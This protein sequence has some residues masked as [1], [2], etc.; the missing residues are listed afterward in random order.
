M[1]DTLLTTLNQ[2]LFLFFFILAGYLLSRFNA[3]DKHISSSL[4]KLIN[5]LFTPA[6]MIN[7]FAENFV[8]NRLAEYA[9]YLL[10]CLIVLAI[11]IP[12]AIVL[13][14]LISRP[15]IERRTFTY[16]FIITNS[17]FLGYPLIEAVFGA[18]ILLKYMIFNIPTN[19]FI[20][21]VGMGMFR[22][23]ERTHFNFK[24]LKRLINPPLIAIPI[25]I[26]IGL[27]QIKLPTVVNSILVSSAGCMAPMAMLMTGIVLSKHPIREAFTNWRYYCAS[28]IRLILIPAIFFGLFMLFRLFMPIP[29][30]WILVA[31]V[32]LCLPLGLNAVVFPE[33]YGRDGTVGAHAN[34]ISNI[35]GLITI[36]IAFALLSLL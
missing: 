17:G 26:L 36:P 21:T 30:E 34:L 28:L 14:R 1:L 9:P 22:S 25:G 33:Y 35:F 8:P 11:V 12:L 27:F 6:L 13:S 16:S 29:S 4:S 23:D 20:Y 10:L 3:V 24:E 5:W 2:M 32:F 31:L 19:V 15:G 18:E 7:T